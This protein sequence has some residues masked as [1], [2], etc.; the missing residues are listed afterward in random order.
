MRPSEISYRKC[1]L[2]IFHT[3]THTSNAC[4]KTKSRMFRI[5]GCTPLY[6]ISYLPDSRSLNTRAKTV[7]QNPTLT[8]LTRRRSQVTLQ[9]ICGPRFS[10]PQKP[11]KI[12]QRRWNCSPSCRWNEDITADGEALWGGS[13]TPARGINARKWRRSQ[14]FDIPF[15]MGGRALA[16]VRQAL[17]IQLST[18]VTCLHNFIQYLQLLPCVVNGELPPISLSGSIQ[19]LFLLLLL[20]T[21]HICLNLLSHRVSSS[22]SH[23]PLQTLSVLSLLS[24]CSFLWEC[25]RQTK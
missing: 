19:L 3:H 18:H 8:N 5:F 22:A 13:P 17:M 6:W 16:F 1:H 24:S 7:N 25:H 15:Q 2:V 12:W 21:P 23:A 9:Q 10:L 20:N 14:T 4:F 11:D